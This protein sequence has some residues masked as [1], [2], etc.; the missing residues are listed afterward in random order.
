MS[1]VMAEKSQPVFRDFLGTGHRAEAKQPEMSVTDSVRI[2]QNSAGIA[3]CEEG[4]VSTKACSMYSAPPTPLAGAAG[5]MALPNSAD[6]S[7]E[8]WRHV[9][10]GVAAHHG[11][12]GFS[13]KEFEQDHG[14]KRDILSSRDLY[15]NAEALQSS[16]PSKVSRSK[17][18]ED[19]RRGHGDPSSLSGDLRLSMQPPRPS[20][21]G[22]LWMQTSLFKADLSTGASKRVEPSRPVVLNSALPLGGRLNHVGAASGEKAS[23]KEN[24]G[25]FSS[26]PPPPAD[27]GSRT[28]LQGTGIAHLLNAAPSKSVAENPSAQAAAPSQSKAPS[29]NAGSDSA[30]PSLHQIAAPA[31]RQLTIFYGGQAH[32]FDDVSPDKADAIM[33]LAGSNGR[34][35]STTYAHRPSASNHS[36]ASEG[37]ELERQKEKPASCGTSMNKSG[38]HALPSDVQSLLQ[39]LAR[40]GVGGV[41]VQPAHQYH[42]QDSS[43]VRPSENSAVDVSKIDGSVVRMSGTAAAHTNL[44]GKEAGCKGQQQWM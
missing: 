8:I 44:T 36:A 9:K 22:P 27:E 2:S 15:L 40:A 39:G 5:P 33:L 28:G 12:K 35:W 14:K 20:P 11:S 13:Y 19:P 1:L 26:L 23:S 30:V 16:R 43:S 6:P 34:S 32:V 7:S 17:E 42:R 37:L 4:E 25:G 3:G 10:A 31:T 18:K 21:A 41:G 29:R 38:S 24:I